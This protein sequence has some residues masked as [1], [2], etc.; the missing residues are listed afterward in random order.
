MD[1]QVRGGHSASERCA[2]IFLFLLQMFNHRISMSPLDICAPQH[3]FLRLERCQHFFSFS[4]ISRDSREQRGS[5]YIRD[6][7]LSFIVRQSLPHTSYVNLVKWVK[8]SKLRLPHLYFCKW[9]SNTCPRGFVK[10]KRDDAGKEWSVGSGLYSS[11]II[12]IIINI[13]W[14]MLRKGRAWDVQNHVI[15]D[16]KRVGNWRSW[17]RPGTDGLHTEQWNTSHQSTI[18]T[19]MLQQRWPSLWYLTYNKKHVFGHHLLA[20]SY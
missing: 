9:V 2:N 18:C 10:I 3:M 14:N 13:N 17:G 20:Q 16:R 8:L 11:V 15:Q 7:E 6:K 12:I 5:M 4:Y 19:A 1:L